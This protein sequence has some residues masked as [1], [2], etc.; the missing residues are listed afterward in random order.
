MCQLNLYIV[1]KGTNKDEMIKLLK[2]YFIFEGAERVDDE[3]LL[4][5]VKDD[6]DVYV[7]APMGC[8]CGT[9]QS[10]FQDAEVQ[11][12]WQE[13]KSGLISKELKR[14]EILKEFFESPDYEDK[15]KRIDEK[16][17]ELI[18]KRENAKGRELE[19]IMKE[20]QEFI[21]ENSL[22]YEC[23]KYNKHIDE[24]G[25]EVVF[26]TIQE[27]IDNVE[28]NV[29][30]NADAE[31]EVLKNFVDDVLKITDEIKL[32]SYWQDGDLPVVEKEDYAFQ[33][34][35]KIENIVF[36]PYKTLL[37]IFKR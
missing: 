18:K 33:D 13:F 14:L 32:F 9:V 27:D 25:N 2:K 28:K 11:T 12:S 37:T 5:E 35:L 20:T 4:E 21:K 6:Y 23:M 34:E 1:K 19:Q 24:N 8:N 31:F 7:S 15:V 17:K 30:C 36:M 29:A 3:V 26:H 16:S 10:M 22:V